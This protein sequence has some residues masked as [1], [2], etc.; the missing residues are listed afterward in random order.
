MTGLLIAVPLAP[1]AAQRGGVTAEQAISNARM[2]YG[3]P[4][5][6]Q[7]CAKPS[8]NQS[9]SEIVVCAEQERDYSEFRVQSTTDLDPNSREALR[10]GVPR[11]P[12]V[13]GEGIFK[14]K[15]TV[16]GG[17]FLQGC[18]PDPAYIVDFTLLPE[19]PEGS[20]ADRIARGEKRAN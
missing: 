6:T 7:N 4:P 5:P 11:A 12:D 18:P 14:G 3:P 15:A 13:A 1:L 9:E 17:C 2:S 16:T 20:D 8:D 10:D 19:A